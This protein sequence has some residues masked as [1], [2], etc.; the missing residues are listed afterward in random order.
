[1]KLT[2]MHSSL[3]LIIVG[4]IVAILGGTGEFNL[5]VALIGAGPFIIGGIAFTRLSS[6]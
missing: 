6:K 5:I 3:A 2:R 4:G 1:M